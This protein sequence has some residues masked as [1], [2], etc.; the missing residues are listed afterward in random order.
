MIIENNNRDI[1]SIGNEGKETKKMNIGVGVEAHIIKVL[2]ENSYKQPLES[3]IRETVSNALDSHL[4]AGVKKPIIVK[5]YQDNTRNNILEVKDEGLGLDHEGFEKYI[6]G[7]GESTKRNNENLLG[8]YGAGAK[9]PLS[10]CSSFWYLCR[11]DGIERK[12]MIFKGESVPESSLVYEK[13]TTEPNGVTVSIP[14]G[15][16]ARVDSIKQQLA[17]F[18][19]VYFEVPGISNNYKIHRHKDWQIS[20]L[21][22]FQEMHI[23]LKDVYY[24]IEWNKIGIPRINLPIGLRFETYEGIQPVFNREELI[25]TDETKKAIVAKIGK[26]ADWFVEKYNEKV[27]AFDSFLQAYKFISEPNKSVLLDLE[28]NNQMNFSIDQLIPQASIKPNEP[29]V[30]GIELESPAYYKAKIS[31]LFAEYNIIASYDY[32][33]T[34]KTKRIYKNLPSITT[35]ERQYGSYNPTSDKVIE[36]AQTPVG[37]FKEFIKE[38]FGTS[39]I[40][41]VKTFSRSRTKDDT[42]GYN[43]YD[44]ILALEKKDK[45]D[46]RIAEWE[47]VIESM[48]KE[49]WIDAKDLLG[50]KEYADWLVKRKE[51]LKA[52]RI[53][54]S[55]NYKVLNKQE[56]DITISYGRK[57]RWTDDPVFEKGTHPIKDLH[58][59]PHLTI[60]FPDTEKED[61]ADAF[62]TFKDTGIKVAVIGLRELNKLPKNTHNFKTMKEFM[63]ENSKPFRRM[64]TS[65]KLAATKQEFEEI[66]K[67]NTFLISECVKGLKDDYQQISTYVDANEVTYP[68]VKMKNEMLAVAEELN[69]WDFS[70]WHINTRLKEKMK[71][72]QFLTTLRN[73][74]EDTDSIRKYQKTVHQMLLFH[75]LHYGE[76]EE[77]DLVPKPKDNTVINLTGEEGAPVFTEEGFLDDRLEEEQNE[78][79]PEQLQEDLA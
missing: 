57:H 31:D 73:P 69:L 1:V 71:T 74:T 28:D 12:Y 46:E 22:A 18:S 17:Y 15:M 72:F 47:S 36:L 45:Q 37:N 16:Y 79:T 30:K 55:G 35:G 25:Y 26:V 76:F 38:K 65:W 20:G 19:D 4:E 6:M 56:G 78:L 39:C 9:A 63:S 60:Y 10:F 66:F 3:S 13:E 67:S 52:G 68:N 11:K 34:W 70:I 51:D 64:V 49:K 2:T 41:V 61:A 43:T 32:N 8:G 62:E 48:K 23:C 7:L 24:P 77:F 50:S 33:S 58:K 53:Q 44:Y 27:N 54:G 40:Y 29:V 59:K 21:H 75:K 42:I 5:V 14:L